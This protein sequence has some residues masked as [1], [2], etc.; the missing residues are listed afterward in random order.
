M[1]N[2]NKK[3]LSAIQFA[4]KHL[5]LVEINLKEKAWQRFFEFISHKPLAQL[6]FMTEMINFRSNFYTSFL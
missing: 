5:K 4:K 2:Q 6:N 3:S 1:S